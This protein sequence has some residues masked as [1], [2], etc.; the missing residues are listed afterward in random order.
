MLHGEHPQT[1]I[2]ERTLDSSGA[3][4][5]SPNEHPLTHQHGDAALPTARWIHLQV[6]G[7]EDQAR[8]RAGA[9]GRSSDRLDREVFARWARIGRDRMVGA[10]DVAGPAAHQ[11]YRHGGSQD[12]SHPTP[13]CPWCHCDVSTRLTVPSC[14]NGSQLQG[15]NSRMSVRFASRRCP[16]EARAVVSLGGGMSE[17]LTRQPLPEPSLSK[18]PGKSHLMSAQAT[19]AESCFGRTFVPTAS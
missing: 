4:A 11:E 6:P 10:V 15:A 16:C 12:P 19:K 9:R 13:P 1:S 18:P 2:L 3:D 17:A 5:H 7:T 14:R 8:P